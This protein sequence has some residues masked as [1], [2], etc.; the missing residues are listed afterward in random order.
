M[1]TDLGIS[2]GGLS[3]VLA[4]KRAAGKDVLTALSR[5]PLVNPAWLMRGEG[6]PIEQGQ[7]H[8]PGGRALPLA[9]TLLP[10]PVEACHDLLVAEHFPVSE[11]HFRPTRYWYRVPSSSPWCGSSGL[12]L[13]SGDLLL[14]ETDPAYWDGRLAE[15]VASPVGVTLDGSNRVL[16]AVISDQSG[17]NPVP[18]ESE[19]ARWVVLCEKP[20]PEMVLKNFEGYYRPLRPT[21][22]DSVVPETSDGSAS[23][24]PQGTESLNL[25]IVGVGIKLE[26][27]FG[28]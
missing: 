16:A 1:A 25:K 18:S 3:N 19:V 11:F 7:T 28:K 6:L 2:P 8:I 20:E 9:A 17:M 13:I 27:V 14:I 24:R 12:N 26:R 21:L 5:H 23:D 15:L 22:I 4:G 10:G